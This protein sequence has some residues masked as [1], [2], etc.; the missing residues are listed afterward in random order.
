MADVTDSPIPG[1]PVEGGPPTDI[2]GATLA[3]EGNKPPPSPPV[4]PTPQAPIP[5][6][7]VVPPPKNVPP[8][9]PSPPPQA[10]S[11][12]PVAPP[13]SLADTP[14]VE[15]EP[16]APTPASWPD[17]W[18]ELMAGDDKKELARLQRF[19][20]PI[21]V[22]NA[23]RGLEQRLSA[24]ELKRA[25]P[26]NYTPEELAEYRKSNG[27][28]EKPE[29][30]DTNVGNGIV[31][32]EADKPLIEDWTKFAHEAN[33]PGEYVKRGLEWFARQEQKVADEIAQRDERDRVTG[34]EAL[35]TEWGNEFKGNLAA[36]RNLFEGQAT[37][38]WDV[39]MGARAEDGSRL[40][41]RPDVLKFMASLSREVNPFAKLVPE[42]GS[43]PL[44]SAE[45]RLAEITA[46]MANKQGPYW[47]GPQAEKLQAEWRE[48]HGAIEKSKG[49][50]AA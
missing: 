15:G 21:D 18:R 48:L 6:V 32:G 49:R 31:W 33:I 13:K 25:L 5:G 14:P 20:S 45:G 41:N 12:P 29:E 35:R 36:A 47:R 30:Y 3:T 11:P 10:P 42:S 44:K 23:W 16:K 26:N 1:A 38:L 19:N 4:Q 9:P 24:G 27:I 2:G 50:A 17:N 7:P 46:M 22:R 39:L 40:G 34:G 43:T 8:A 28:P 37:P